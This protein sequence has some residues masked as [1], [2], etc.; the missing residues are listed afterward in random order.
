M[1]FQSAEYVMEP[2]NHRQFEV[3]CYMTDEANPRFVQGKP[4]FCIG[5]IPLPSNFKFDEE[6]F[7]AFDFGSTVHKCRVQFGES[8]H[9]MQVDFQWNEFASA[10]SGKKSFYT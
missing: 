8:G 10:S 4:A 2:V 3:S 9:P 7:V 6:V 1:A 5:P